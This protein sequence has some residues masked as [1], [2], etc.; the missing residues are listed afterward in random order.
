[1]RHFNIRRALAFVLALG[2]SH[3]VRGQPHKRDRSRRRQ[4]PHSVQSHPAITLKNGL[5]IVLSE[6]HARRLCRCALHLTS[7]PE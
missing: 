4:S 5:R 6:D 1:M 7:V 2:L 3:L